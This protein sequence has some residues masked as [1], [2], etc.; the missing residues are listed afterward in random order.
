MSAK[1]TPQQMAALFF[2]M[3]FDP[4][5]YF[6][7]ILKITPTHQQEAVLA[8]IRTWALWNRGKPP[9]ERTPLRVAI[10]SGHGTGKTT[11][12]AGTAHWWITTRDNSLTVCTAP[13]KD[14][15]S[16]VLWR[17]FRK[18]N[19]MAV[20]PWCDKVEILGDE[21]RHKENPGV[22]KMLARTARRESPE[23]LQGFHDPQMLIICDEASGIPEE[24]FEVGEGALSTPGSL[25]LMCANPTRA[26]GTFYRAFN[27]DREMYRT[28]TFNRAE[29]DP[30]IYPFLDPG[31]PTRM[32]AKY[33]IT[34]NVYR[35]RV[36]G[37]FPTSDPDVLIPI[38][39][40][41]AAVG[42]DIQPMPEDE[43]VY[44][45][46]VARY[47]D[48][49]FVLFKRQGNRFFG[50]KTWRNTD[51]MR[52]V[53]DIHMEAQRDKPSDMFVDSIGVGG[54]IADR[55][56]QLGWTVTDVNVAERASSKDE[57]GSLKDELYWNMKELFEEGKVSIDEDC[58]IDPLDPNDRVV[59]NQLAGIKYEYNKKNQF[60]VW[61]KER[62]KREN[63]G[64]PDRAEAMLMTFVRSIYGGKA[65]KVVMPLEAQ[66]GA[67]LYTGG[68]SSHGWMA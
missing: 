52:V 17:E 16:D 41:E 51:P 5:W 22:W 50:L 33:G 56:R 64:S 62:Y 37:E 6:R 54:P 63:R 40:V 68:G 9:H 53:L 67:A 46:D 24:I 42:R 61:S 23:A 27:Q 29:L 2:T 39:I 32:A 59:V 34:S 8:E 26:E 45:I 30:T 47:G 60:E 19:G 43:L 28:Y 65:Q 11:F 58:V 10:K 21:I 36:L 18:L 38:H 15:L 48:D 13:K 49:E 14:Q 66:G 25:I 57:F 12:L 1:L 55:L 20:P 3:K 31:Y 4:V 7:N 35:V 44:G